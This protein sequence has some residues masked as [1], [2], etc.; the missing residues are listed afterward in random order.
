[1]LGNKRSI[2]LQ[3][4][5]QLSEV[6]SV[7][8]MKVWK[9]PHSLCDSEADDLQT[10]PRNR[11]LPSFPTYNNLSKVNEV[12]PSPDQFSKV[13]LEHPYEKVL[14][15]PVKK[16]SLSPLSMDD[17]LAKVTKIEKSPEEIS[18]GISKEQSDITDDCDWRITEFF[19]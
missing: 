9:R 6:T 4:L 10:P 15:H 12:E 17:I 5:E 19:C 16:R 11:L 8:P 13:N 18:N 2:F 14:S 3:Q 1:M 7:S